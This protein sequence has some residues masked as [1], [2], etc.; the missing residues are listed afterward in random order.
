MSEHVHVWTI[1]PGSS[2]R[3]IDRFSCPCGAWGWRSWSK[4]GG[5]PSEIRAYNR[6]TPDPEWSRDWSDRLE[7]GRQ[8]DRDNSQ[9]VSGGHWRRT[10]AQP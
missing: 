6:R 9:A 10:E 1:E 4:D 8:Y 3:K 2:S 5:G 7:D